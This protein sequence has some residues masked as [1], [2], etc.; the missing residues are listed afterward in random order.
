MSQTNTVS[1]GARAGRAFRLAR[2]EGRILMKARFIGFVFAALLL[3]I[4]PAY[5]QCE[6]KDDNAPACQASVAKLKGLLTARNLE[7]HATKSPT[8]LTLQYQGQHMP[9]MKVV[10]ALGSGEDAD[11]VM[12][13]TVVEKYR[14]PA[15]ADFRRLLLEYAYSADSVKVTFDKD[16]DL[17]LRIDACMRLADAS[18]LS[19]HIAQLKGASDE[20]YGKIEPQLLPADHVDRNN[21][22]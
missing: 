17:S 2:V 16:G 20:L 15:D 7:Y 4:A 22:F 21:N 8:V 5:G 1:A 18:Y 6:N 12:F 11:L 3:F 13:V 10:L 14:M 19:K 9:K